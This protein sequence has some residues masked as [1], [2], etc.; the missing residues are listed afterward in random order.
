VLEQLQLEDEAYRDREAEV[1]AFYLDHRRAADVRPNQP[2][3]GGDLLAVDPG[4]G[5]TSY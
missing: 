5:L 3:H 1:A 4:H 2:V